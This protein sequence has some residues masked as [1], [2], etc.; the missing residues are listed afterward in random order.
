[1]D[2]QPRVVKLYK[3]KVYCE[4]KAENDENI[5]TSRCQITPL[6]DVSTLNLIPVLYSSFHQVACAEKEIKA[7]NE[8]D[9]KMLAIEETIV[10]DTIS[11]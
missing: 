2:D 3:A 9:I 8:I 5:S 6:G 10:K 4:T 1:M 7:D 11:G